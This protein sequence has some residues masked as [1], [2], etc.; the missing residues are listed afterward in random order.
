MLLCGRK[1]TNA[2]KVAGVGV[3]GGGGR[4]GAR[5]SGGEEPAY[6]VSAKCTSVQ[7]LWKSVRKF[8]TKQKL[9][10]TQLK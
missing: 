2:G 1:A 6:R 5:G 7:L 9:S 3:G 4:D 8:L 10:M